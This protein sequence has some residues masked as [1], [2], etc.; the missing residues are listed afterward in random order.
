MEGQPFLPNII[1][2]YTDE[3]RQIIFE[4]VRTKIVDGVWQGKQK[5]RPTV[6]L[7]TDKRFVDAGSCQLV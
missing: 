7:V 5:G 4:R 3:E 1:T 2:K 6:Q